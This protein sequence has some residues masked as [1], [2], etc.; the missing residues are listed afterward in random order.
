MGL[1]LHDHIAGRLAQASS[2]VRQLSSRGV[3]VLSVDVTSDKPVI[4]VAPGHALI[5]LPGTPTTERQDGVTVA[6][7]LFASCH[8]QWR[9]S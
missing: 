6:S 5:D 7:V 3:E 2:A 9:Y 1:S 4:A 8:V